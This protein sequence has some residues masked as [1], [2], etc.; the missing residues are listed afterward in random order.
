M[1]NL[2]KALSQFQEEVPTIKKESSNPFFKSKYAGLDTI[3]PVINP[4]L[5]KN[6]LVVTQYPMSIEGKTYLHTVLAHIESGE[7]IESKMEL[8]L[9]KQ[10]PQGQGSAIT[11]ARRYSIVAILGLNTEED[12]DGNKASGNKAMEVSNNNIIID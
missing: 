1:K 8:L 6:G 4:L 5:K 3:I 11:Y 2:F 10:D 7:Q 9:V 12:D